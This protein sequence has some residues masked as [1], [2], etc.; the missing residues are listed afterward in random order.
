M[1]VSAKLITALPVVMVA[2]WMATRREGPWTLPRLFG[3][4]LILA[5]LELLTVARIQFERQ[6]A[7]RPG[8]VTQGIYSR[9]R[10]PL[11]L[12]SFIAFVGLFLYLDK[13]WGILGLLPIQL[14]QSYRARREEQ[15]L[16]NVY[17]DQYRCYRQQ[18]WF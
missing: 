17:G 1:H 16:E 14:I 18:T 10:H 12:F 3:L 15:E 4:A 7:R 11:Y 9:V 6:F 2:A 8:L 5:G 13:P